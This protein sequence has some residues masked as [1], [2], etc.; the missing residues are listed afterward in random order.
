MMKSRKPFQLLN[1]QHNP[2]Q[3]LVDPLTAES[4]IVLCECFHFR[5]ALVSFALCMTRPKRQLHM[6]NVI[7]PSDAIASYFE[8]S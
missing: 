1:R 3:G 8:F 5:R 4:S 2:S 6:C 7:G